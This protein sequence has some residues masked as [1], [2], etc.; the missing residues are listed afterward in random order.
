MFEKTYPF[1]QEFEVTEHYDFTDVIDLN[2]INYRIAFSFV[3]SF[4]KKLRDD[5][6]YVKILARSVRRIDGTLSETILGFHK[7]E[8]KDWEKFYPVTLKS[9]ALFDKFEKDE[10]KG[11]YC[12]DWES[13]NPDNLKIYG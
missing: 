5:P 3:N 4:D 13:E 1:L 12:L 7:C 9:Q 8:E 6:R 10:D 11:F 2:E